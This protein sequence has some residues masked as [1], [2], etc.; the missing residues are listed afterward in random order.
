M[1]K[2]TSTVPKK[3]TSFAKK[4]LLQ[5]IWLPQNKSASCGLP[6]RHA[7]RTLASSITAISV[8]PFL[9]LLFPASCRDAVVPPPQVNGFRGFGLRHSGRYPSRSLETASVGGLKHSCSWS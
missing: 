2:T 3:N 1:E 9:T 7:E 5:Q 6:N 8:A 4:K